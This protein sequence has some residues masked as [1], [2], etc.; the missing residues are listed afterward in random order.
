MA[1]I[2]RL[3]HTEEGLPTRQGSGCCLQ[4]PKIMLVHELAMATDGQH[5]NPKL[6]E[7]VQ[8]ELEMAKS[9][10]MR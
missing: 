4:T 3:R 6:S 10:S 1:H 7:D 8:F 9:C 5:A 2:P